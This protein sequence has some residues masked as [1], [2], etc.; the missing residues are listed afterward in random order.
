MSE[1][2]ST[3]ITKNETLKAGEFYAATL[4][5]DTVIAWTKP[6]LLDDDKNQA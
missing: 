1:G 5:R 3:N 2:P 4:G 6:V